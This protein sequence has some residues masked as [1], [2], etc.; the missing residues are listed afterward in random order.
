MNSDTNVKQ[1]R[2]LIV[3]D[4]PNNLQ[5]LRQVL[6]QQYAISL[7]TSGTQAIELAE[8]LDP[9]LILLDVMMPGIDGYETCT[10]L[11]SNTTTAKIPVIFVTAKTETRDEKTGFEVG[12]VDY[13]TKPISAP[14]VQARTATHLALYDQQRSFEIQLARKTK[15]LAD[16]QRAAIHMLGEAGHYN[17]ED[18]GVHIWR[19]AAYCEAIAR[20]AG[21]HV[22]KAEQLQTAAPM[23]DTGKIGIPDTVLKKPD[24]LTPEEWIIMRNHTRIGHQILS[25]SDTPLFRMA[26]DIALHHHEKW[27]GSGYPQGVA[28]EDIPESARIVAIADVFDALTMARPYKH[29]WSIDRAFEHIVQLKGTHFDPRLT[30]CFLAIKDEIIAIKAQWD[31]KE[32]AI[33][34]KGESLLA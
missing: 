4:E 27:D 19:M 5:L 29:P 21:W 1:W 9:D 34:T 7:A 2:I 25:K 13:I 3:D 26:A 8:K 18:T 6:K 24:K 33:V 28:G 17:D 10:R 20:R 31:N 30:D 22:A 23:H 14:T 16:S 11:K 15:A 12:A 32:Q